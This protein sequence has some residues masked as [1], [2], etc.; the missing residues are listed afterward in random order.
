M[1]AAVPVVVVVVPE[2]G[3]GPV[4]SSHPHAS[5]MCAA[6]PGVIYCIFVQE[7]ERGPRWAR[8]KCVCAWEGERGLLLAV[9]GRPRG[10]LR[11]KLGLKI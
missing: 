6:D 9:P 7:R 8:V 2:L 10:V 11:V 3:R 5:K 4:A 1:A